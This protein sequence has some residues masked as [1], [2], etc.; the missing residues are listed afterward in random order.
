M[1]RVNSVLDRE[2]A[3]KRIDGL[4]GIILKGVDEWREHSEEDAISTL[5]DLL[6]QRRLELEDAKAIADLQREFADSPS[7]AERSAYEVEMAGRAQWPKA[8][9]MYRVVAA[10]V[11]VEVRTHKFSLSE[12]RRAELIGR[13]QGSYQRTWSK[14]Y[15]WLE[16]IVRRAYLT[17]RAQLLQ[18]Q[19]DNG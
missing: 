11:V 2:A 3:Y 12:R 5:H 1:H 10:A 17:G 6:Q 4:D 7:E 14:P 18:L 8:S 19:L 13:T 15:V 9:P 16:E